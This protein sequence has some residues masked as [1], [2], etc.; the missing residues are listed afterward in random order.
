MSSH[1]ITNVKE[2]KK[3]KRNLCLSPWT[4]EQSFIDEIPEST[5]LKIIFPYNF[6]S[7]MFELTNYTT[8]PHFCGIECKDILNTIPDCGGWI[9]NSIASQNFI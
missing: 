2:I 7:G 5:D 1:Q 3:E 6:N 4:L 9:T 8:V